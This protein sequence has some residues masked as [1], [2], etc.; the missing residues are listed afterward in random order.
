MTRDEMILAH[1]HQRRHDGRIVG[2][3]QWARHLAVVQL[4]RAVAPAR[5]GDRHRGEQPPRIGMLGSPNT[6][7]RGPISTIWPRYIT[8]TRWL[9]RSTTAMS[10]EMNR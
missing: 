10:C 7:W 2:P 5:I 6:A 4:D 3:T 8:A 1:L 9:T